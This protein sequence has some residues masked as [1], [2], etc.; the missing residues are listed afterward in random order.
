MHQQL[1]LEIELASSSKNL[2]VFLL[3]GLLPLHNSILRDLLACPPQLDLVLG[4]SWVVL[5]FFPEAVDVAGPICLG[6]HSGEHIDEQVL[7]FGCVFVEMV[8]EERECLDLSECVVGSEG[9]DEWLSDEA[10]F[11][12]GVYHINIGSQWWMIYAVNI[13]FSIYQ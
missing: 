13:S 1:Q 9:G 2:N 6:G 3:I 8:G 5:A 11:D 12:E 7:H 4:V 10:V